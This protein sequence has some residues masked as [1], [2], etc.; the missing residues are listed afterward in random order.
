MFY[1]GVYSQVSALRTS[2]E[3]LFVPQKQPVIP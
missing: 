1:D 3:S 2:E